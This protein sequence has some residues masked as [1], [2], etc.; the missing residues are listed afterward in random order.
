MS[1]SSPYQDPALCRALL[2]R[3]Q[4][5]LD[6]RELRFME[7]CGTHTVSIFQSGLRSL[8]P[9]E[10]THLSGPGC[11][12]CVTHD[13][14]V[15]AF[16]DLAGR[17]GVIIATFG[18]LLRVPGPGGRSLKHAQAQGARIE[19]V[20]SPLDALNIAAANPGDTV[21][22]LGIG[23]ETT[24][25]TVAAT[26]MMA[27]Q[28]TLDNFCVLSLHKLVPPVLRALLDIFDLCASV[29]G[30]VKLRFSAGRQNKVEG[31][32]IEVCDGANR[33][34]ALAALTGSP[35]LNARPRPGWQ[36]LLMPWRDPAQRFFLSISACGSE[37]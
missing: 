4:T 30:Q 28:R 37:D 22:F 5:A 36:A 12:V 35:L 29:G 17:D 11:P 24:A 33:D 8:L 21:V 23:F 2:D 15:A 31:I 34:M 9:K 7:V 16:L 32:I 1:L 26:L 10:V 20:Y 14:E 25:P 18:D 3:L 27:E 19:I 13:A 6:G